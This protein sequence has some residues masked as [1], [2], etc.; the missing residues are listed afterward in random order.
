MDSSAMHGVNLATS[1]KGRTWRGGRLSSEHSMHM[2]GISMS[3]QDVGSKASDDEC[4][5]EPN[6]LDPFCASKRATK[7]V[8]ARKLQPQ[9]QDAGHR[10]LRFSLDSFLRSSRLVRSGSSD[11]RSS[12]EPKS[13]PGELRNGFCCEL[14]A[15][16]KQNC[17]SCEQN[18]A[19]S[20]R[21]RPDHT[22][23]NEFQ[24]EERGLVDVATSL[25]SKSN[26]L[27]CGH[28]P[29]HSYDAE[30]LPFA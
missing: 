10:P 24:P 8:V 22:T 28:L 29:N 11:E 13:T 7:D 4:F 9:Q 15:D 27:R 21:I 18:S 1:S 23:S 30:T 25:K 20:F 6:S 2:Y 12:D 17:T 14:E 16:P 26:S 5:P 19:N 3:S